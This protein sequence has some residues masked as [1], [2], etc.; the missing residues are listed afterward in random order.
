MR[1]GG[2]VVAGIL[3]GREHA[4]QRVTFI[5]GPCHH[6]QICTWQRAVAAAA[7]RRAARLGRQSLGPWNIGVS[8]QAGRRAEGHELQASGGLGVEVDDFALE[9][10]S[11]CDLAGS[12]GAPAGSISLFGLE[13]ASEVD[14]DSAGNG[15]TKTLESMKTNLPDRDVVFLADLGARNDPD[16]EPLRRRL[17][18]PH[19]VD[20]W[21]RLRRFAR[22]RPAAAGR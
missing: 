4:A 16:F 19:R 22:W 3:A 15:L 12:A 2:V 8:R 1:I 5:N 13:Q 9:I 17:I 20:R 6:E 10:L 14:G 11:R 18:E 7:S 21:R